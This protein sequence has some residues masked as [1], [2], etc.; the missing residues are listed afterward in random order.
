VEFIL[1]FAPGIGV[2]DIYLY[3]WVKKDKSTRYEI[4]VAI[5][6]IQY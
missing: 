4:S 1:V 6:H 2:C 5:V 3:G